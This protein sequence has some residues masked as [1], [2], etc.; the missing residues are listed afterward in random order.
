MPT[1]TLT[2][3][4]DIQAAIMEAEAARQAT[5]HRIDEF[6]ARRSDL[7]LTADD[8]TLDKLETDLGRAYRELD[9]ADARILALQK[10]LESAREAE[11]AE[12]AKAKA[13]E[14]KELIDHH[15]EIADRIDQALEQVAID[16]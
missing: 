1:P 15:L 16:L 11:A 5:S 4:A 10:R 14:A 9:R 2:T 3:A 13:Q 7:L 12:A 6:A 8:K